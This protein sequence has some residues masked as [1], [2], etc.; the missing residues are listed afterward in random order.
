MNKYLGILY[1]KDTETPQD[2]YVAFSHGETIEEVT[3]KLNLINTPKYTEE[4]KTFE[5]G[6]D[7]HYSLHKILN[8]NELEYYYS[9]THFW[10]EDDLENILKLIFRKS[11]NFKK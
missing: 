2:N 8:N 6:K 11:L 10:C 7:V 3:K 4:I 5:F 9:D 1:H